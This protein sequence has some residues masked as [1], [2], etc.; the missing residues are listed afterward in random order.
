MR[1][2]RPSK[3]WYKPSSTSPT[4]PAP[5]TTVSPSP[6]VTVRSCDG[7][8]TVTDIGPEILDGCGR[9]RPVADRA[10]E[11]VDGGVDLVRL[12]AAAN[13]VEGFQPLPRDDEHHAL[14]PADVPA[15]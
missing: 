13:G 14:V 5:S 9:L 3:R 1:S 15:L 2:R 7:I 8:F 11:R 10:L 4:V 12:E 6:P